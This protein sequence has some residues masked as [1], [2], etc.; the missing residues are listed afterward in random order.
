MPKIAGLGA[1]K[2]RGCLIL[3]ELHELP[4]LVCLAEHARIVY[5]SGDGTLFLH[6]SHLHAEVL[7]FN[8]DDSPQWIER[9]LNAIAYLFGE[10]LLHLQPVGEDVDYAWYLAESHYLA[11]GYVCYMHLAI[12][13]H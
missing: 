5:G 10:M 12:K 6:S 3:Y 2:S 7:S 11:V 9:L 8:Y 1:E 13:R 4:S